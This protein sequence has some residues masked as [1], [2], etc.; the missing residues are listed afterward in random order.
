[1]REKLIYL[2]QILYFIRLMIYR[3]GNKMFLLINIDLRRE[4][5]NLIVNIGVRIH[6]V[7]WAFINYF[8]LTCILLFPISLM[9][10]DLLIGLLKVIEA[11]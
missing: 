10:L 2:I 7:L 6:L 9:T 3:I 1:M 11:L 5:L 4:K 8:I